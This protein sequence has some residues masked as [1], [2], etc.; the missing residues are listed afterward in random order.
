MLID[1]IYNLY[2]NTFQTCYGL[3]ISWDI[4]IK[5]EKKVEKGHFD[6]QIKLTKLTRQLRFLK[7]RIILRGPQLLKGWITLSTG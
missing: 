7:I 5:M 3:F 2:F 1:L 4:S 6:A